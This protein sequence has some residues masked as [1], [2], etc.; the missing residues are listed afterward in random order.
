[1]AVLPDFTRLMA[2]ALL[3]YADDHGYFWANPAMVR[4]ALFPFDEDSSKVRRAF[5]QLAA[6]G[7]LVLGTTADGREAGFIVNFAKHQRVD[8]KQDSE[9]QPLMIHSTNDRRTI[10]DQSLLDRKGLEGI[11]REG[12]YI[13]QKAEVEAEPQLSIPSATLTH[14]DE[15]Y[16]VYPRKQGKK[17]ALKAINAA[18]KAC[19]KQHLLDRTK[20][21]ALAVQAWSPADRQFIP[22]PATWFNRGSY[23]DDPAQWVRKASTLRASFA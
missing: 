5:A 19:P 15:I 10:D 3:N 8:R 17:D 22:H 7:Y 16:S 4:G 11:G 14:A 23:D 12:I 6:E 2:L 13:H 20:A 1:M 21:F 9:I 18:L